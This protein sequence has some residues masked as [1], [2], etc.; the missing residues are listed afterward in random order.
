MYIMSYKQNKNWWQIISSQTFTYFLLRQLKNIK[1][2]KLLH[3]NLY[4]Y[5]SVQGNGCVSSPPA[6]W[7]T[8]LFKE[9]K[10]KFC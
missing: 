8:K 9:F 5:L 1:K 2:K 10:N 3:F 4:S 6:I 7:F